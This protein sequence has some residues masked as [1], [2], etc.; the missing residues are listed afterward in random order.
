[1]EDLAYRRLLDAYYLQER[2]LNSGTASVARQ[3]G[4]RD[5][6]T[7]VA[8]VLQEF[9]ELG[10][11]GWIHA[12]ADKEIKH[13][14]SKIEQ[15]SRAGKASAE[16]RF[17]ARSTQVQPTIN[18]KP[19]TKNTVVKPEGVSDSVWDAF[20]QHRKS[21][22]AQ[23]SELVLKTIAEQASEAGWTLEQA[24]TEM[25]SRGWTGFKASWVQ[26]KTPT[27]KQESPEERRKRL[28]FL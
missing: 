2:P 1:M 17:N 26:S 3:I 8:L 5:Q 4:M 24:L 12:R 22:K 14:Y 13:F 18:H 15:A 9:F 20:V 6:E 7:E 19:I 28:A 25:V 10:P 21:K 23:V 27:A 16:R 11:D